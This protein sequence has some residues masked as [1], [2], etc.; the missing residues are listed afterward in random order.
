MIQIL[1]ALAA[2]RGE[3]SSKSEL[4]IFDEDKTSVENDEH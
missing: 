2:R 3:K 1:I 4:N